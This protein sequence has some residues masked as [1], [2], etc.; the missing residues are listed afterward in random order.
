MMHIVVH[1][2]ITPKRPNWARDDKHRGPT[3]KQ[4]NL[5]NSLAQQ[6]RPTESRQRVQPTEYC[7]E[8]SVRQDD[9]LA[10]HPARR[11]DARR[12]EATVAVTLATG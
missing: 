9:R 10:I 1:E 12:G 6:R 5:S 7:L 3:E 2:G 11:R 4:L 8:L